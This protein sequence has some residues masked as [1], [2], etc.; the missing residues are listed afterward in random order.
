MAVWHLWAGV[1]CPSRLLHPTRF[2]SAIPYS[3]DAHPWPVGQRLRTLGTRQST[4]TVA[5]AA[6]TC[7]QGWHAPSPYQPCWRGRRGSDGAH[8]GSRREPRDGRR[9]RGCWR[10]PVTR[11]GWC[12]LAPPS[13]WPLAFLALPLVV[14]P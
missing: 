5:L 9:R 14:C 3:A 4:P 7:Q 6:P 10:T 1:V 8:G 11:V 13:V 12:T 2:C